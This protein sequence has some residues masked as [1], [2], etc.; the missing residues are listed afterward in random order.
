M[1]LPCC[2]VIQEQLKK[3]EILYLHDFHPRWFFAAPSNDFI[4][5]APRPIL[6]PRVIQTRG[7]PSKS[8]N[9]QPVSSTRREASRFEDLQK[10][11]TDRGQTSKKK[12]KK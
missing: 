2:H 4:Q 1:G 6:N 5:A 10:V 8:K 7:R 12:G 3:E 11:P 9:K